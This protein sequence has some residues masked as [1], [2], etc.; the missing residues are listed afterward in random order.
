MYYICPTKFI[1]FIFYV[2]KSLT[3]TGIRPKK[4]SQSAPKL[5]APSRVFSTSKLLPLYVL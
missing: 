4:S 1:D 5:A 2:H 3:F